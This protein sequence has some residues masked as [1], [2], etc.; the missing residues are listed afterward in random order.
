MKVRN[1]RRFQR[2]NIDLQT[3]ELE[4][5]K[6]RECLTPEIVSEELRTKV[7]ACVDGLKDP[8]KVAMTTRELKKMAPGCTE[9]EVMS[10]IALLLILLI[11]KYHGASQALEGLRRG[12]VEIGTPWFFAMTLAAARHAKGLPWESDFAGVVGPWSEHGG[13]N[14]RMA[15]EGGAYQLQIIVG[16]DLKWFGAPIKFLG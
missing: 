10:E 2:Y 11:E 15:S 8:V 9:T 13:F 1:E 16:D 12:R 7:V 6:L 3:V 4:I 5:R 14:V